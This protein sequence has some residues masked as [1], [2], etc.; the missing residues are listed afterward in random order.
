MTTTVN[1]TLTTAQQIFKK[2]VLDPETDAALALIFTYVP[3]LNVW[4]LSTIITALGRWLEGVAYNWF[5]MF[6]DVSYIKLVDTE[7]QDAYEA[8][9]ITLEQLATSG[10]GPGTPGYETALATA[11]TDLSK[12]VHYQQLSRLCDSNNPKRHG[13]LC[14]RYFARW[15]DMR[16]NRN[17]RNKS[18]H[19]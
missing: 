4:P 11:E 3:A 15:R 8:A 14:S 10:Q 9:S 18:T 12:F 17:K 19:A 16:T 13:V 2:L 5:V 1:S 6:T 7:M